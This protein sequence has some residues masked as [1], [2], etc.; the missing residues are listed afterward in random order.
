MDFPIPTIG[1]FPILMGL[2]MHSLMMK[3]SGMI[4]MMTAT[5]TTSNISMERL[6]GLH[7]EEGCIA[8]EGNS[9]MDRW[10]C[11]DS[12]GDGWSDPTTH[13]LASPGGLADGWPAD[14]TQWHDRDGDGRGDNPK[15]TTADV[16]PDVRVLPRVQPRVVT[17]G[18]V[19]TP[20]AMDGP[21]KEIDSRMSLHS[22]VIWMVRI[23]RQSR[24]S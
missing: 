12:D 6:G 8:T 2:Q 24:W 3:H 20:M 9:A 15:G 22:G 5:V 13:W 14:E 11:P 18:A 16:C 21:T 23:W 10:G 1:G 19:T 17:D 7:G 4:Q